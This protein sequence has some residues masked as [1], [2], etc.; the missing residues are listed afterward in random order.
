MKEYDHPEKAELPIAA[1]NPNK[2]NPFRQI[3][4]RRRFDRA[5]HAFNDLADHTAWLLIDTLAKCSDC[6]RNDSLSKQIA[7]D[8]SRLNEFLEILKV[9]EI[10][11]RTLSLWICIRR[12]DQLCTVATKD[13]FK[14]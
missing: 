3:L 14:A 7:A 6:G 2:Q 5:E 13:G 10:P 8:L 1:R 4:H 11:S 12:Y 9:N